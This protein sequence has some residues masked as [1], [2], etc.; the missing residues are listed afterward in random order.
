MP[1]RENVI[2]GLEREVARTDLQWLDCV[3]VELLKDA[4]VLLKEHEKATIEPKRI[5]LT[6]ETKAWLDKMDAVDALGN[7]ADICMDWDG[8]RTADGLGGLINE[9]W[10]YARYCAD[11]L[12]I[13]QEPIEARLHLCESCTKE[14][15]ECEADK[16]DLV[17]GSGVGNDNII[18]CPWYVNRWKAQ[19][20]RVMTLEEW[21]NLPEPKDGECL[22]YEINDGSRLQ[23]MLIKAFAGSEHLYGKAFRCWTSRPDEKRRAE[24]P[25]DC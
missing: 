19:E 24:T 9:I 11:R 17:Y 13:V 1:D 10:A 25:W 6:D 5:D 3:E 16:T 7:I 8:Y 2:N 15:A 23:A 21:K 12:S 20:P 22:C 18:G 4:L 14:Y